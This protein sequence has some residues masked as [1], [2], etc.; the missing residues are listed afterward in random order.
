[1]FKTMLREVQTEKSESWTSLN[2]DL[3]RTEKSYVNQ[4]NCAKKG[5]YWK[6]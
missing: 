1:M 6:S 2:V 3:H 5:T 4:H